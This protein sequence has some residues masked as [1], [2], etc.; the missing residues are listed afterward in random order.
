MGCGGKA[1][2]YE[3]AKLELRRKMAFPSW[4]GGTRLNEVK[5]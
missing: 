1:G 3:V 5:Y 4:S 2:G